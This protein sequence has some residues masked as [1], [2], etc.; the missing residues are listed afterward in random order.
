MQDGGGTAG[1]DAAPGIGAAVTVR[2]VSGHAPVVVPAETHLAEHLDARNSP[3]LF[4]CR[5]GICATCLS[6]VEPLPGGEIAPPSDD[7]REVL[8]IHA[9]GDPTARLLCQ[10]RLRCDVRIDPIRGR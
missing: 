6:H 1:I 4:G 7:E 3:V 5:T 8:D 2:F 10:L 9:P